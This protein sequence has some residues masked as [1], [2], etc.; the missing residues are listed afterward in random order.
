[1]ENVGVNCNVR[2]CVHNIAGAKCN[3]EKIDVTNEKTGS[4]FVPSLCV[5][6]FF[7]ALNFK[8]SPPSLL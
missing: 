5:Y 1:M 2:E 7:F 3:L 8:K 4:N 6:R